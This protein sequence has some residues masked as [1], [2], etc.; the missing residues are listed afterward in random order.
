M[1]REAQGVNARAFVRFGTSLPLPLPFRGVRVW[2]RI[3]I[4][5]AWFE[6]V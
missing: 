2:D 4:V 1:I 6:V 5:W 3:L